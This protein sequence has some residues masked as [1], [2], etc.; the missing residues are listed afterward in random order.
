MK[1]ATIASHHINVIDSPSVEVKLGLDHKSYLLT[2]CP[3]SHP[4][5]RI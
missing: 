3:P 2:Y 5:I 1:S 4:F